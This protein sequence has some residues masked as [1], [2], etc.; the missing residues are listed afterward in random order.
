MMLGLSAPVSA[1]AANLCIAVS[2]GF[3]NGGTSFVAPAFKLPAANHCTPWSGFTKTASTV[4]A[5]TNG[6]A[7]LSKTGKVLTLS[8]FNT[9]PQFFGPGSSA[10]DQ[11]QLCPSGVTGCP[12]SGQD[13]GYFSGSAAMQTCTAALLT[14][15]DAHD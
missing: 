1:S 3:G 11:I 13:V 4:I 6:T 7:C 9:D 15:P 14:L 8:L 12:I 2:G 5:V 10:S